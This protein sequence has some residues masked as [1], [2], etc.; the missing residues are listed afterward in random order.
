MKK[1]WV[2][3]LLACVLLFS[4]PASANIVT[5]RD[6][7]DHTD[8]SQGYYFLP[9]DVVMDHS[10][11]F[12]CSLE[13]WDWT[14]MMGGKVPADATGIQGATLTILAWDVDTEEG[15]IDEIYANGVKLGQLVGM[16]PGL[17]REWTTTVFNL[18]SGVV[19]ELW[20]NGEVTIF[21]DIDRDV[22]GD[23]VN[24]G[25]STLAVNY[26]TTGSVAPRPDVAVYRF[27]SPVNSAH[28]YT[29]SEQERDM[30]IR[31][32]AYVWT[33]EGV[34]Y[35][36]FS[37]ASASALKPVYR[38]WSGDLGVHFYTI[39]EQEKAMVISDY[40][41][42]WT[43]EGIAF[44]AYPPGSQPADALPVYRFWSPVGSRHFY[45]IG[46]QEKQMLVN[47]Y[48]YYWG[49]EGVAWYAYP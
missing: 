33:Y 17:E 5:V 15:E 39:S 22:T 42:I 4:G 47:N 46:E 31:D 45:T 25:S 14:H 23:R 34:A 49:L 19:Q 12:R 35:H 28:F 27:W 36:A 43:Y 2:V 44:Y 16:A 1:V 21:M 9:P 18:P 32:Y 7:L 26:V 6:T 48:A 8:N 37:N 20:Q 24:I 41:Y 40:A 11:Y 13:D 38:F 30:L 29:I 10:P 3:G